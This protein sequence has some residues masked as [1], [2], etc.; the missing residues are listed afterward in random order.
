MDFFSTTTLSNAFTH[1]YIANNVDFSLFV[2]F[3]LFI[4][5]INISIIIFCFTMRCYKSIPVIKRVIIRGS[6]DGS[7]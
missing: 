7:R 2:I 6:G 3:Y 1:I 4:V 5:I